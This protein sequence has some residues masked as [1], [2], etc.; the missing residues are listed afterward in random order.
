MAFLAVNGLSCRL[1]TPLNLAV[2]T[3]RPTLAAATDDLLERLVPVIRAGVVL[4]GEPAPF[5]D[6]M[7]LYEDNP[8]PGVALDA[9][10]LGPAGRGSMP[11]SGG[12]T[13]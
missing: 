2:R 10:H 7:S 3:P 12:C 6:P 11:P 4:D 9:R 5:D 1:R 8:T 13:S